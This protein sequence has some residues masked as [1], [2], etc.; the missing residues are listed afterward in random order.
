M[1]EIDP[2][3]IM[4]MGEALLI[5]LIIVI[6]MAILAMKRISNDKKAVEILVGKLKE[7]RSNRD[8]K[9]RC[10]LN[11]KYHYKDENLDSFVRKFSKSERRFYQAFIKTYLNR[12]YKR[13]SK[14]DIEFDRATTPYFEIE[15]PNRGDEGAEKE[16]DELLAKLKEDN[17]KLKEELGVSMKTLGRMLGEYANILDEEKQEAKGVE[18]EAVVEDNRSDS[19]VAE[20]SLS[21]TLMKELSESGEIETTE[22]DGLLEISEAEVDDET[23]AAELLEVEE[24]QLAHDTTPERPID[25]ISPEASLETENE[26]LSESESLEIVDDTD[27]S[28]PAA[29]S[30][31]ELLES[32]Q[33]PVEEEGDRGD[34]ISEEVLEDL[35]KVAHEIDELVIEEREETPEPE[36]DV[37]DIDT[38]LEAS[39]T[40]TQSEASKEPTDDLIDELQKAQ[41]L[42]QEIENLIDME[43]NLDAPS[44]ED[45][46]KK[47]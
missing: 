17:K 44:T 18:S 37:D 15:L 27:E 36:A 42:G 2:I 26:T 35:D 22:T 38:L 45:D 8:E 9:V 30:V 47:D 24:E 43:Q 19:S 33:V 46:G 5:L 21:P 16:K 3:I 29:D 7:N 1:I 10:M 39:S 12:D 14:L 25:A 31:D 23:P 41:D 6:V 32:I 4:A 40:Q 34:E 20:A 28:E 11:G 13:L